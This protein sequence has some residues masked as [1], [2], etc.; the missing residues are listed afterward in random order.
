MAEENKT[1]KEN[2]IRQLCGMMKIG[3]IAADINFKGENE[4]LAVLMMLDKPSYSGYVHLVMV[5]LFG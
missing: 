5:R 3:S 2:E 1:K 4:F